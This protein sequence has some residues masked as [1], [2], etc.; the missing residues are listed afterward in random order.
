[1]SF[2]YWEPDFGGLYNSQDESAV[3][4]GRC[5]SGSNFSGENAIAEGGPRYGDVWQRTS[6]NAND[7]GL[8]FFYAEYGTS[9]EYLAIIKHNGE[10]F[11]RFYKINVSTGVWTQVT[12]AGGVGNPDPQ[13]LSASARYQFV[14][15]ED[16]VYIAIDDGSQQML[17]RT[18]GTANGAAAALE[19]FSPT[20]NRGAGFGLEVTNEYPEIQ[21][22]RVFFD[23]GTMAGATVDQ[24]TPSGCRLNV[25]VRG[26]STYCTMVFEIPDGLDMT[27]ADILRAQF[28]RTNATGTLGIN[29]GL[30][31]DDQTDLTNGAT[32]T[33]WLASI[34][35]YAATAPAN[36][37]GSTWESTAVLTSILPTPSGRKPIKRVVIQ[38][39]LTAGNAGT[40]VTNFLQR[41]G[42]AIWDVATVAT[43]KTAVRW[44]NSKGATET[45]TSPPT[46]M[47]DVVVDNLLGTSIDA[48]LPRMGCVAV[49]RAPYDAKRA[50]EGYDFVEFF[51]Q[52]SVDA[53]KYKT[54]G[55]VRNV[56]D[57]T[58]E[59]LHT[60]YQSEVNAGASAVTPT[61]GGPNSSAKVIGLW[62]QH[63][64]IGD[65]RKLYF[66]FSSLPGYFIPPKGE[67][68]GSYDTTDDEDLARTV[69]VVA[70][71]TLSA[72]AIVGQEVFY[73]GTG[74]GVVHMI[75]DT[76]NAATPPR[77]LPGSMGVLGVR[78]VAPYRNGA[79]MAHERGLYLYNVT[80]A[81]S[82]SGDTPQ[83]DPGMELTRDVRGSWKTL[84]GSSYSNLVVAHYDDEVWVF[85][86]PS[87][88]G[89]FMRMTRPLADGSRHWYEGDW[90]EVVAAASALGKGLRFMSSDGKVYRAGFDASGNKYTTDPGPSNVTW[91]AET[92]EMIGS[93]ERVSGI[94][95]EGAGTP[96]ITVKVWDGLD[97]ATETSHTFTRTADQE[98]LLDVNVM[99]GVR[100][101]V[102]V[103]GTTGTDS[104]RKL[105]LK[106]EPMGEGYGN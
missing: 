77:P 95:V 71:R 48:T 84:I 51:M 101:Q 92:G 60:V 17:K 69:W 2:R 85:N 26:G 102:K 61:L 36:T 20:Y 59:L 8:G 63:L 12:N 55:R 93:R 91:Q 9:S 99:P 103:S 35:L 24:I 25:P 86:K 45:Y 66:S 96:V 22:G 65:D 43:I 29:W 70:G 6:A 4:Q 46:Q 88:S 28:T 49:W 10:A 68:R 87:S 40:L 82:S 19:Y 14:Q 54:V 98:W 106:M 7:V 1:M 37:I 74:N 11:A 78:A 58:P 100:H 16:A 33:S 57:P 50:S 72:K 104:V 18:V 34:N 81:Y 94:F 30:S 97:M 23:V 83:E 21:I 44:V 53:T 73:A 67:I 90:P 3:P 15:Y 39:S 64:V 62:K 32:L 75:G 27:Q 52:S 105:V 5:W 41:G 38:V 42:I 31:S 80:R 79:L 13:N 47:P 89:K 56:S 76:A